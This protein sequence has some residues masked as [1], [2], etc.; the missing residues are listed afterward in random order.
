MKNNECNKI[1]LFQNFLEIIAFLS[2]MQNQQFIK[3]YP[4]FLLDILIEKYN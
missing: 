3:F 2:E 1:I 4:V